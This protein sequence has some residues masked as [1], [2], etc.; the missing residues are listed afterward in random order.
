M[1]ASPPL[2]SI[3]VYIHLAVERDKK[4][5]NAQSLSQPTAAAVT[6]PGGKAAGVPSAAVPSA[7]NGVLDGGTLPGMGYGY[8]DIGGLMGPGSG[9][10]QPSHYEARG[11]TE[12]LLGPGP[13][14]GDQGEEAA[15]GGRGCGG[16]GAGCCARTMRR[17]REYALPAAIVAI[18][19][20]FSVAGLY[21]GLTDLLAYLYEAKHGAG[22]G[23]GDGGGGT[24]A[25]AGALRLV[26]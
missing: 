26:G 5:H 2:H 16:G 6:A 11:L 3:P 10:Q 17:V 18:G 20:G 9:R 21:V 15:Q 19:V 24:G 8:V 13:S 12:P 7:P 25:S 22:A 23:G 14:S 1:P 4:R